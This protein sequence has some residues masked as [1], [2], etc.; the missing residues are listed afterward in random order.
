MLNNFLRKIYKGFDTRNDFEPTLWRAVLNA[1]NEAAIE[2]ISQSKHADQINAP[3]LR[4]IKH[5]NEVFAAFKVH[6]MGRA[7]ASRL[8]NPNGNIRPFKEWLNAVQPIASHHVGAWLNTEYNTAVLRAHQ[9]ADW[10]MFVA[11]KDIFP[12]LRWMPT[13]APHAEATHQ[14]YWEKKLTLPIDHPFWNKHHPADRWNC[15]CSLEQTDQPVNGIN[16]IEEATYTPHRGLENNAG[17]DG[18]LFNDTHPYFAQSC[19]SCPFFKGSKIKNWLTNQKKD[20]FN[21]GYINKQISQKELE[22]KY[23]TQDWEHTYI[24]DKGGVVVTH[25]E[26][27]VEANSSKNE[28]A[29]YQK[30]LRM[31]KV[32]ADNGYTIEHLSDVGRPKGE[33][34]DIKMNGMPADLKC[35][36][37]GTG[38]VIKY[39]SKALKGQGA[40]TAVFEFPNN[41][42]EFKNIIAEINRKFDANIYYYIKEEKQIRG[43]KEKD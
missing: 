11:N 6:T 31:C 26:R 23:S 10:Q 3:F 36:D 14:S 17:K 33:T 7:M 35:I 43:T 29:K 18:H 19:N 21:C 12:N 15:K 25:K 2:G 38:N 24:S 39:L 1:L 20:C 37:G 13:T 40:K 34:Y 28:T 27:L 5:S 42:P 16:S 22:A 4:A 8:L 41:K 30:E 9:A 32:L